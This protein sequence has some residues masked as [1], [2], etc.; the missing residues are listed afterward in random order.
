MIVV[1][2]VHWKLVGEGFPVTVVY[3]VDVDVERGVVVT[4]RV[5]T[6]TVCVVVTTTCYERVSW[7]SF[8]SVSVYYRCNGAYQ[9]KQKSN[10]LL[11]KHHVGSCIMICV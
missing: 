4:V 9:N 3:F 7:A 10:D 1:V 6:V 8:D 11:E 2:D 5:I